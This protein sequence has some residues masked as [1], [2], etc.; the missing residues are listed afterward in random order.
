MPKKNPTIKVILDSNAF[1]VPL[2][3][4]I[5]IFDSLKNLFNRNLDCILL[6]PVK[7]ELQL[8]ANDETS[9]A[10]REAAYALQLAQKCTFVAVEAGNESTDDIIVRVAKSWNAYV[11]TN[12]RQLKLRLRDI[13]V[14]VIYLRQKSRLDI[15]GLIS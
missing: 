6:S 12:D 10:R 9:K 14:P 15:D 3:F 8:L 5:D 7:R 1:F 4:K 2:K 13:S 11:F